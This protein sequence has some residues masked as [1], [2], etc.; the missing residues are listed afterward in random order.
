M[1]A[2][3]LPTDRKWCSVVTIRVKSKALISGKA[4]VALKLVRK[5]KIYYFVSN[6]DLQI[7]CNQ[8]PNVMILLDQRIEVA[9]EG[10]VDENFRKKRH[11]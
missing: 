10:K 8:Q 6:S 3:I 11:L 1:Q 7:Q 9:D 5:N 4:A 2:L